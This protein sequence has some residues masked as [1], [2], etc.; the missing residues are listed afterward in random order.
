MAKP[1]PEK[2]RAEIRV[3]PMELQLGDRPA[4]ERSEWQV[5]GRPYS[6]ACG[7]TVHVRVESLKQPGV[8]DIRTWGAYERVAVKRG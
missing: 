8:T 2:P 5:I 4:D 6:T 1:R 3:L 7:K